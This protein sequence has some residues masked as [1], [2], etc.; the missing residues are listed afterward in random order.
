[1]CQMREEVGTDLVTGRT[2]QR[3]GTNGTQ[4]GWY[5][6][7][8][9]T[10]AVGGLIPEEGALTENPASKSLRGPTWI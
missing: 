1:M 9:S 4:G 6:G 7:A 10:T 8:S 2:G 5:P 3:A